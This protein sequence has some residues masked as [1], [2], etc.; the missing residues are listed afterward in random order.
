M[1]LMSKSDMFSELNILQFIF[2]RT[3][4]ES[5]G[6]VNIQNFEIPFQYF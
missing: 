1:H 2:G 4:N 6:T 5:V 3:S